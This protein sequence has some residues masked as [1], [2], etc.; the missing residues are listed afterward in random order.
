MATYSVSTS[1][2]STFEGS[3]PNIGT[4]YTYT[5]T[6]SGSLATAG[7]VEWR[8]V[9]GLPTPT[10]VA[11]FI[12]GTKFTGVAVFGVGIYSIDLTFTVN[13]D[14]DPEPNEGFGLQILSAS[15][16]DTIGVDR[17]FSIVKDDDALH[18]LGTPS[19]ETLDL[20]G[21]TKGTV[22]D[23]S[24]GGTDKIIGSAFDDTV[25]Y[26]NTFTSADRFEGGAGFDRVVLQGDYSRGVSTLSTTLKSVEEI[27]FTGDFNYK[28][29]VG[30]AAVDAG[31]TLVINAALSSAYGAIVNAAAEADGHI[32][33]DGGAGVD[34][35]TGGKL[36][37]IIHG[38]YGADLLN[39]MAGAD[40]F[41]YSEWRDSPLSADFFGNIVPSAS[42]TLISFKTSEDQIDLSAFEFLGDQTAVLTKSLSSF[43]NNLSSG[44]NFF[45]TAGVAVEY[46]KIGKVLTARIYV[47]TNKDGDLN[48]GDMLIQATGVSRGSI[49]ANNFTF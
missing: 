5:I 33:F 40:S 16:G 41:V 43:T 8:V 45:G 34:N 25:L 17:A 36:S 23:I 48:A 35:F 14:S 7:S 47:D 44:A 49:L 15:G 32:F 31:Q 9:V 21:F 27:D 38:D 20:S 29:T 10:N 22:G 28:L 24:Q 46:A 2:S 4:T 11:D 18:Y 19:S 13:P 1:D 3:D 39:G 42:D 6:R 26:G 30:N 12:D 37:D